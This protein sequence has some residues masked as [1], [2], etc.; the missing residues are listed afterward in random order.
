MSIDRTTC[1]LCR[2]KDLENFYIVNK[3]PF[4]S[5]STDTHPSADIFSDLIFKVCSTC[6]CVQLTNL[7]DPSTLYSFDNKLQLTPLW[8]DHHTEFVKFIKDSVDTTSICEVGGGSNPLYNFFKKNDIYYSILDLYDCSS[9]N[10]SIVYKIGN[11]ESY[12]NYS[13][14]TVILSHTFEHLYSPHSFLESISK[15]K[16]KNIMLSVPNLH[17]WL[18]NKLTVNLLFN[19]HTF[20]FELEQL[21]DLFNKYG[22][23]IKSHDVF[24]NH[25]IFVHFVKSQST[26]LNI[27]P[28]SIEKSIYDHFNMK[29]INIERI[30]LEGPIYIMPSFYIGQ[31]L[32]HYLINK[33]N[34]LG[35]LDNDINKCNKRLYGTPCMVYSPDII[36]NLKNISIIV[37]ITPYYNEMYSQLM[38]L[39][40]TINIIKV[41]I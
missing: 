20:Y 11:C 33:E 25:S 24:R 15:S 17:S 26:D 23:S 7:I 1:V 14:D 36:K 3:F 34:I 38:K 22:Y 19:Q 37:A 30:H 18:I 5:L 10:D 8:I 41:V 13:E 40:N 6:R 16:V 2:C 39:N 9:I 12:T 21:S 29:K 35:F 4:L 27:R 31:I 32:Y 28:I